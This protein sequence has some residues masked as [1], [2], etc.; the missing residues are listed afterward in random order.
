MTDLELLLGVV[1]ATSF[2]TSVAAVIVAYRCNDLLRASDA[3][4]DQIAEQT[5]LMRRV[6]WGDR[7]P[8]PTQMKSP[9]PGRPLHTAK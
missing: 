9:G 3:A 5:K 4:I 1:A 8:P 7:W 6:L 2:A